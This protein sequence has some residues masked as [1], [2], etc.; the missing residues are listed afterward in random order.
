MLRVTDMIT[1]D[2]RLSFILLPR[3]VLIS[4]LRAGWHLVAVDQR[5]DA[6][7]P[8]RHGCSHV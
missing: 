7:V 8:L 4:L 5:A 2:S 3:S 1:G 6:G